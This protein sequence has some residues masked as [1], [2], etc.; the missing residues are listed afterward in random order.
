MAPYRTPPERPTRDVFNVVTAN[1]DRVLGILLL[2]IGGIRVA[3]AFAQ[4][5]VFA[6]ESTLA[7]FMLAMA[8]GLLLRRG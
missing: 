3:T 7:L 4:H 2:L 1:D 8:I 6:S 5:E